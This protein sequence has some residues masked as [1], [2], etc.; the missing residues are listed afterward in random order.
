MGQTPERGD[1]VLINLN[2]QAGH[3]QMG[4]RAA[5]VLSPKMFNDATGFAV[6]CPITNQKKGYPYEVDLPTHGIPVPGG[7]PVTGTILVD[8]ER[9]LDWQARRIR[10]LRSIESDPIKQDEYDKIMIEIVDDC[11]AKI[12]TFLS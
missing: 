2:P 5:I 10:I 8:Q 6:I 1:L 11:L 9:T 3:E 12:A 7:E 4:R